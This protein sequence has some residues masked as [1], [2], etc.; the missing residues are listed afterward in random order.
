MTLDFGS[1]TPKSCRP[2][3]SLHQTTLIAILVY[4]TAILGLRYPD[5]KG[6]AE[7][8][9]EQ[10]NDKSKQD[11]EGEG[12]SLIDEPLEDLIKRVPELKAL[13]P[14]TDQQQLPMI[15]EKTG[16]NVHELFDQLGDLVAKEKVTE[17][18][19]NPL[20]GMPLKSESDQYQV[21]QDEYSY[22]IVRKGNLLQTAIEEYRRDADG[23]EEA[24]GVL[25]LSSGFASSVLPF[26]KFLQSES[27]FRY[28]GEDHVGSR[29]THVIAFAQ[30][31]EVATV[32]FKMKQPEGPELHWLIQGIAWVD[33][34]SFQIL[35]M[36]T[37]LLVPRPLLSECVPKDQ[38]QTLVKFN[39][40]RLNGL[41]NSL[42]LPTEVHVYEVLESYPM[43][44]GG[45][46]KAHLGVEFRNVHRFTDYRTYGGVDG[47]TALKESGP[48]EL[49]L[50]ESVQKNEAQAHPYLEEPLKQLVE[51]VPE[52][53]GMRPA[54]SLLALPMI[55]EGAG[56]NVDE[57]FDNL[58]DLIA[59]EEIKQERW[60][61]SEL[62][63]D[64]YLI[65]RH[66]NR[67]HAH[68]E[69]FRMDEKGNR[70]D[71]VG[72][73]KGYFV[74]SGFALSSVHFSRALQW[75]S[76]F[77]YLGDQKIDGRETY[78]VG[79][80]QL[81]GQARLA[82]TL[83]GHRGTTVHLL[84]QGIAWVDKVNFQILRMRTDLLA[85]QPEIGLDEQTTKVKFSEVRLLDVGAPLWLPRD[86]N[87][88]VKLAK[89]WDRA[90][91]ET[92]QNRHR[93]KNYRRYRV[94]ARIVAPQ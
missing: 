69:E 66:G 41:A 44:S 59:Q 35:Q 40:M 77:R 67:S 73:D 15:L 33:T 52:L 92:F 38:L 50:E 82:L 13:Q 58:V 20:T 68:V 8:S 37:D 36:R 39:E 83:R 51:R 7:S 78:V 87:V 23:L 56:K 94:S 70:M 4:S 45:D 79:L 60:S 14:A 76:R 57:L 63:R 46:C 31:P 25:F 12:R 6:A 80:A 2:H 29:S 86:V 53:K 43:Q 9:F 61:K 34:S 30:I 28:L 62:V 16:A 27:T 65:L 47:I 26:S 18:R 55:L 32:T 72:L 54:T 22:F 21:Q 71:Q 84:L 91:E 3:V 93:Y 24:A 11:S 19:L 5:A 64:N 42:W 74:T 90:S 89:L 81:P 10:Q 1:L 17:E 75:D 49:S 48:N 88:H 85:K